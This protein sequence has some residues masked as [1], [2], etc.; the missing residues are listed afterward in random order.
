MESRRSREI[1]F[2][3]LDP[4]H[5]NRPVIHHISLLIHLSHASP[6]VP[7]KWSFHGPRI[8]AIRY[9]VIIPHDIRADGTNCDT[10]NRPGYVAASLCP[11][12]CPGPLQI[13][14]FF[15]AIFQ[16]VAYSWLFH[17]LS[18][19]DY[20]SWRAINSIKYMRGWCLIK[21]DQT[22]SNSVSY[23]TKFSLEKRKRSS[24]LPQC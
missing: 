21:H 2:G 5:I 19:L 10:V 3:L 4:S 17:F 14:H 23:K 6:H 7:W 8:S 24:I 13:A 12:M 20:W 18:S 11:K 9:T 16:P 1:G 15:Q 22:R